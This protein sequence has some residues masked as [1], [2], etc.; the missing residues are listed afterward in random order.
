MQIRALGSKVSMV[1]SATPVVLDLNGDGIQT[2]SIEEGVQFDILANGQLTQT[3]WISPSDGLLVM[4]R[5]G[6]KI[7][8]DGSELFG[9]STVLSDGNTSPDGFTA[10]SAIDSNHDGVI[11][12][13][14]SAFKELRVWVD[15]NSDGQS[16]LTELKTLEALSIRQLSLRTTT[17]DA[18]ENGNLLGLT[19][20]FETT[21]GLTHMS[22]DVWF[23]IERPITTSSSMAPPE[24]AQ[25]SELALQVK[26]MSHAITDFAVSVHLEKYDVQDLNG[27]E[28]LQ[29]PSF[30]EMLPVSLMVSELQRVTNMELMGHSGMDLTRNLTNTLD[31]ELTQSLAI[32]DS[33]LLR[34]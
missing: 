15:S 34:R 26:N 21:D 16:T 14:D 8:N 17:N 30:S 20:T 11:N 32:F 22:A 29:L 28:S 7:I 25:H 9:S 24:V 12:D 5:N 33:K 4:D 2:L 1:G 31:T 27:P 10:L 6:D 23:S 3:G 13:S 19:S 18:R